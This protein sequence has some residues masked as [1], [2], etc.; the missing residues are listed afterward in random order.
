M[1]ALREL[2]IEWAHV[3]VYFGDERCLN[4]G[5]SERN[6]RMAQ[7][8]LLDHVAIP[9]E[10]IH[11][12]AAQLGALQAAADYADVMPARLDLVLL[13]LGEDGHTASL[14][15]GNPATT[16]EAAVVAVFDAPK[17]PSERVSLG[18]STLNAAR[19]KLFLISGAGKREP[20]ARILQGSELPAAQITGA[21]WHMDRA[22]C[23]DQ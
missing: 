16:S 11:R 22:A 5:D 23:P 4:T 7:E 13:G 1:Q 12:I 19:E 3:Q 14:F 15:P 6:D 10:N 21:Q 9:A 17:P 20:L 2:P 18:M 8:A